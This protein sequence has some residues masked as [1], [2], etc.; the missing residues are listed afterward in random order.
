MR[1]LFLFLD[2]VGLGK[3]D[4]SINPF[5][6]AYS[7]TI[8]SLLS[9]GKL[10][11][12]SAPY[13]SK[14]CAF[15]GI[16]AK[17]GV[18]GI[19]QSATNQATILTGINFP[20][21]LGYHYGPK[22]N[23]EISLY[24]K[25]GILPNT[26]SINRI[27]E[28]NL[29]NNSIFSRLSQSNYKVSLLNAYPDK[30]FDL[31]NSGKRNHSVIPL[32][33]TSAGLSLF[34]QRDLFHGDAVSAD[35]TGLGWREYLGLAQTPLLSPYQAGE[36]ISKLAEKYD[37]S[38]FEF[39]ESDHIGHK[40]DI[41]KGIQMIEKLDLVLKGLIESW[42]FEKG[43]ILISSDHGNLEDLSTRKHTQNKVPAILIGNSSRQQL[44]AEKAHSISDLASIMH[45]MIVGF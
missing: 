22:P 21:L 16:D 3:D 25:Q 44:L 32:A 34:D 7:P 19:P 26:R 38:I 28:I 29:T 40:Q 27:N 2:G 17:L 10:I 39:W 43:V 41:E 24:F 42:N 8:R 5:S 6:S 45:E 14:D 4:P 18:D 36:K 35:F 15:I 23:N 20:K 31:I 1:V 13:F 11:A 30:Y 37:L 9:G 12:Q 33:I